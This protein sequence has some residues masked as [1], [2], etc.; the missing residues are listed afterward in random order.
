MHAAAGCR[1]QIPASVHN[2][3]SG[4]TIVPYPIRLKS[5]PPGRKTDTF[6]P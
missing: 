5:Y 1:S 6:V 3:D 4:G 2:Q